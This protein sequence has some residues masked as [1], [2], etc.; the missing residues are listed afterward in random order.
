VL[1]DTFFSTFRNWEL[2]RE[3]ALRDL[4]GLSKGAILGY[5]WAVI[6]PLVRTAAYVVI[7]SFVLGARLGE[8]GGRFQYAIYVLSGMVPW[9]ILTRSLQQAP[10][11]IRSRMELVKQVIYPIET[12][13][14]SNLLSGS[15]G[16]LVAF[17]IF[18]GLAVW[19]GSI[20]WSF[21]LIPVPV[22]LL[23]LLVLGG[24]WLFMIVGVLVKDLQEMVTLVLGLLVYFSPVVIREGMVS[25]SVWKMILLNPLAHVVICFRDVYNAEMHATSW[26]AFAGMAFGLV[27]VGGWVV[28]R[29]R[30][31]INEYI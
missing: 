17:V 27:L 6:Q 8:D 14:I 25:P 3:T 19:T 18:L 21:L 9:E 22:A 26:A 16:A 4:T 28:T 23:L 30:I 7:V 13:P 29:A 5:L 12:L 11:L 2:V 24:A 15:I 1:K 31:K 20:R 10:T